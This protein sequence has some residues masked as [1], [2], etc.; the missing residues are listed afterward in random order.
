MSDSVSEI[1]SFFNECSLTRDFDLAEKEVLARTLICKDFKAKTV[2][3]WEGT[4]EAK[5]Y[6]VKSGRV[7]VS[8]KIRGDIE[9]VLIRFGPGDFFGEFS[10]LDDRPRSASV[11]TETETTLFILEHKSWIEIE[12]NH[13][14]IASKFYRALLNGLVQRIR[15][16]DEKLQSTMIWGIEALSLGKEEIVE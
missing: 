12:K 4:H 7:I 15:K 10:L 13:P 3:F 16:S 8:K 11:Q 1:V 5:M 6:F 9:E 2:I 14:T